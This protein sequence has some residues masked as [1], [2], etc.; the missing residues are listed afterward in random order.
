MGAAHYVALER[1]IDGLETLMN[2]KALAYADFGDECEA[3]LAQIAARIGVT[4]LT[5]Y[6]SSDPVDILGLMGYDP[7]DAPQHIRDSLP[8]EEWFDPAD[9]LNCARALI[10]YLQEHPSV[11]PDAEWVIADLEDVI[12]ILTA[13]QTAGVRWH[14]AVDV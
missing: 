3:T 12:R 14:L 11:V 4:P 9:G 10:P 6:L 7:E 13:A 5:N 8:A 1:E 2:G